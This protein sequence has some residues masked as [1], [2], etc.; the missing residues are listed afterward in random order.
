MSTPLEHFVMEI[1][2]FDWKLKKNIVMTIFSRLL[3]MYC[4]ENRET[5]YVTLY[6]LIIIISVPVLC[7]EGSN[8]QGRAP[9]K[10]NDYS[11]GSYYD[12]KNK[13]VHLKVHDESPQSAAMS[14]GF[15]RINIAV[16]EVEVP[17]KR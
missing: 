10:V 1:E 17:V 11:N 16:K 15:Y 12:P 7:H 9:F 8:S 14:R 5:S 6:A 2:E 3:E 13:H 4:E